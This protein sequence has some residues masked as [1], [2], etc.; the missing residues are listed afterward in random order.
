M[1]IPL[2]HTSGIYWHFMET[3]IILSLCTFCDA[4][5]SLSWI[6]RWIW[7]TLFVLWRWNFFR[8]EWEFLAFSLMM[9]NVGISS[10]LLM[11]L[12]MKF[13]QPHFSANNFALNKTPLAIITICPAL[14]K[15]STL[16]G[17][18]LKEPKLAGGNDL[19]NST[20]FSKI[21]F[22]KIRRW[23]LLWFQTW[24]CLTFIHNI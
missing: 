7:V 14:N 12:L 10:F 1:Q 5:I 20:C 3:E 21:F 6:Q 18:T 16:P 17:E 8:L 9:A 4:G 24:N 19:S 2:G 22:L 11:Q 23:C 13:L 15:A